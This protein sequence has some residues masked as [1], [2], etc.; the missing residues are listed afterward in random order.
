MPVIYIIHSSSALNTLSNLI[1]HGTRSVSNSHASF[2]NYRHANKSLQIF[3]AV[4][5]L[6][7]SLAG[8]Y[9][10]GMDNLEPDDLC[11]VADAGGRT[12]HQPR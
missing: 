7:F 9:R 2:V 11:L 4:A 6:F 8:F 3:I 10:Q 12:F 1:L 5:Y